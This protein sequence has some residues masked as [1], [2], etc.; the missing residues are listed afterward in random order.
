VR[1]LRKA[2]SG[3]KP[4]VPGVRAAPAVHEDADEGAPVA[5]DAAIGVEGG[6]RDQR[7]AALRSYVR[8]RHGAVPAGNLWPE[9]LAPIEKGDAVRVLFLGVTGSGKTTAA[10]DLIAYATREKTFEVILVHDSKLSRPE[11]EGRVFASPDA[12]YEFD[13]SDPACP[14]PIVVVCTI[15][16]TVEDVCRTGLELARAGIRTLVVIGELSKGVTDGGREI[17]APSLRTVLLEG[18]ALGVSLIATTQM[19]TR[20]PPVFFDNS[21]ICLFNPG[22]KSTAFLERI[23]AIGPDELSVVGGLSV[24]ENGGVGE[25]IVVA[26]DRDWDGKVYRIDVPA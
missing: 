15:N 1:R 23:D 8:G 16:S 21:K 5:K 22:R 6:R 12:V 19:P 26:T 3:K 18:R 17:S 9:L 24:M 7:D 25:F 11:F 4:A 13:T 20:T 10:R 2:S 14:N